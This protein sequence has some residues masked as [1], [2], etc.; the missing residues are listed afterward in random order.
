M[1]QYRVDI[2]KA[3]KV[4]ETAPTISTVQYDIKGHKV[5]VELFDYS[6]QCGESFP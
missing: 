1:V 3:K 6:Y 2:S 5:L 4:W